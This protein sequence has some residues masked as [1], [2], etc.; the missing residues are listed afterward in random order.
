VVAKVALAKVFLQAL[1]FSVS[2]TLPV[3]HSFINHWHCVTLALACVLQSCLAYS[4]FA[5]LVFVV[6]LIELSTN[7]DRF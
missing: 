6:K 4:L 7:T 2:V 3:L 1:G 5:A